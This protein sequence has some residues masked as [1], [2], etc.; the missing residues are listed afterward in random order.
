MGS[1]PERGLRI[2]SS[3]PECQTQAEVAQP[4]SVW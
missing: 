4:V 2:D 1:V 3:E